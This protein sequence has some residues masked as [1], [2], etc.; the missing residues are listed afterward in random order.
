MYWMFRIITSIFIRVYI[1]R[2]GSAVDSCQG[3][4]C[5]TLRLPVEL[6]RVCDEERASE[7]LAALSLA[8]MAEHLASIF[9]TEKDRVNCPFYFKIGVCRHGDRCSRLHNRPTAS[10]TLLLANMYQSPDAGFHGGVDQHGNIQQSDPRKLQ[11]HFEV[12][13]FLYFVFFTV[14]NNF[15]SM[16][17]CFWL[18]RTAYKGFPFGREAQVTC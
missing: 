9:G 8:I 14:S 3:V 16:L 5:S 2:C 12:G 1:H 11:E 15:F 4:Y 6:F 10:Q 13:L 17:E 18:E 7:G